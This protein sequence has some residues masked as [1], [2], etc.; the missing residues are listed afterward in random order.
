MYVCNCICM[1]FQC[2]SDPRKT[3]FVSY[4]FLRMR[5]II[6][7]WPTAQTLRQVIRPYQ[8]IIKNTPLVFHLPQS[9][10]HVNAQNYSR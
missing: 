6:N 10:C 9:A 5:D 3:S 4:S 8:L 1:Y 7:I 2:S